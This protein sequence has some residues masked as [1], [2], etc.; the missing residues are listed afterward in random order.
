MLAIFLPQ[1]PWMLQAFEHTTTGMRAYHFSQML[2][3]CEHTTFHSYFPF[4]HVFLLL[5]AH[6]SSFSQSVEFLFFFSHCASYTGVVSTKNAVVQLG[7]HIRSL[8][9]RAAGGWGQGSQGPL[10][11]SECAGTV[12]A[13]AEGGDILVPKPRHTEQRRSAKLPRYFL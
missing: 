5:S 2:Q 6:S 12:D 8:G 13:W 3:A 11:A 9:P 10:V 1:P 7:F 4:P